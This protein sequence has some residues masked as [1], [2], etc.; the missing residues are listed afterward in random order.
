MNKVYIELG[1]AVNSIKGLTGN[2]DHRFYDEGL[3][4]ACSELIGLKPADVAPVIY[5]EWIHSDRGLDMVGDFECSLCH[6]PSGIK[7]FCT[8]SRYK[9]CPDC[10]AKMKGA[11]NSE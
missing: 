9:F 7:R 1:D 8:E 11:N 3:V 5:G 4:D 6:S 10:G 2:C